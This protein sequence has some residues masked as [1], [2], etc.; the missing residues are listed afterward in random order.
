MNR[1]P[2][3]L[4]H[5][6]DTLTK[7]GAEVLLKH[8]ISLLPEFRHIV[9]YLNSSSDLEE[10][11][12][13]NGVEVICLNHFKWMHLP[14]SVIRFRKIINQYNPFLVHSH[15]FYSTLLSRISVPAS[16]PLVSTLHSLYSKDAFE[17]NSKSL[18][19]ERLSIKKRHSIIAVSQAALNDYLKFIPAKGKTFV[20]YN[21]LPDFF[22]KE[23]TGFSANEPRFI[24][25]GN[26]KS[27][28]NYEYLFEVFKHL[29]NENI[30]L[31][32]YGDGPLMNDLQE[33]IHKNNLKIR[34]CGTSNDVPGVYRNYDFFIQAS[35][36]EG[37]GLAVAEAMA[38]GLPCF[39]SDIPVFHEVT[40]NKAIFF[41]LNDPEAAAS[42]IR[43]SIKDAE[44][45]ETLSVEGF[46]LARQKYS[47]D[48]YK[49][50]LLAIYKDLVPE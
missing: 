7:G 39:L 44:R 41:T 12:R 25:V 19:A 43:T 21:F 11:F 9:V 32:I 42:I 2:K 16:I 8:T 30:S 40:G 24:S 1:K 35:S 4:L 23:K 47:A 26:L 33:T 20:L 36:H 3:T 49:Q 34:L 18:C 29:V 15:L 48:R 27:A 17:Q 13:K 37:F 31:D 5:I 50:D 45:V 6:I 46:T 28:K 38:S 14:L 22:F 10:H